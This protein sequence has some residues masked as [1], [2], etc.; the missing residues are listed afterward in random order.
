MNRLTKLLTP[1]GLLMVAVLLAIP[2]SADDCSDKSGFARKAC[3]AQAAKTAA[4][5]V[6]VG[7]TTLAAAQSPPLSTSLS[8][9]IHFD[10][11]PPSVE[12]LEFAPLL[13]LDR[14]EDGAFI[15]QKGVFEAYL[16]SYTLALYDAGERRGAAF[17]PAPIE[18]S[19]TSVIA[20]ILKYAELHPDVPQPA[21]QLLVSYTVGGFDL[22]KMPAAV[23]QTAERL[24]PKDML[25]K[26]K[27]GAKAK[28]LNDTL[29][30][31]LGRK[32]GSNAKTAK[33]VNG[34]IDKGTALNQQWG[35]GQTATEM[36]TS[37]APLAAGSTG[38]GTWAQLPGG[39][40]VRYLPEAAA[41]TRLQILVPEAAMEQVDSKKPLTFDPTQFVA[42]HAGAPAQTLGLTLRP[43]GG[44]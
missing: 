43:V 25:L 22:E 38:R 7:D 35:V 10:T 9:A 40:Y 3:E 30:G 32:L 39:F 26:L 42:V 16:E 23:R 4:A 31:M 18:G 36:K 44:R 15:L 20:A 28:M 2:L 14:T 29:L 1:A 11:L 21:I 17:F 33:E 24:L 19:R 8:D 13:K 5:V 6:D 34:A 41:R 37:S 27:T 12:P